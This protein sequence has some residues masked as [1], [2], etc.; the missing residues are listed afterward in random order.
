M[1][2]LLGRLAWEEPQCPLQES[3]VGEPLKRDG[4]GR[5]CSSRD[6][7]E[8]D[9]VAGTP[10]SRSCHGTR[11]PLSCGGHQHMTT[12]PD[13]LRQSIPQKLV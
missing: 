12:G 3:G 13:E 1:R 9:P 5:G 11:S 6:L 10:V 4:H 2:R 7:Y 8:G